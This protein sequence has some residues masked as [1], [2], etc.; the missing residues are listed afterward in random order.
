MKAW[1]WF[2][3]TSIGAVGA[4][5]ANAEPTGG[6]T[7]G[8]VVGEDDVLGH[9]CE[10]PD[11]RVCPSDK[12]CATT[13][14]NRCPGLAEEGTCRRIPEACVDVYQPTCGCDGQT[15]GN[16][17]Q[18]A[19]LGVAVAYDGPCATSCGGFAGLPCPGA[20]TCADNETDGCDPLKGDAD[21]VSLCRCE[22][23]GLCEGGG[24]WDSSPEVCGCVW[25]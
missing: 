9:K 13:T 8:S 14:A 10:G 18:A 21:C 15:Y 25:D 16:E 1:R 20:G 24:R 3:L 22:V 23:Q 17:C 4:C 6:A 2:A 11:G 7:P 12:F 5:G 19:V